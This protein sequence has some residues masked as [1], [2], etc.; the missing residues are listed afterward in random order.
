MS[1]YCRFPTCIA[2]RAAWTCLAAAFL[3]AGAAPAAQAAPQWTV[4]AEVSQGRAFVVRVYDNASSQEGSPRVSV[5]WRGKTVPLTVIPAK[6][7]GWEAEGLLAMPMDAK[8]S[9]PLTIQTGEEKHQLAVR[10]LPV[11]WHEDRITVAPKYVTPPPEVLAQIE[12]DR[13]HVTKALAASNPERMWT[14]P[15]YRPVKG[16]ISGPFGGRRVLNGKPRSPHKGT[17]MRGPQGTPVHAVA[18]GTVVLV[19]PQYYSGNVI[20]VDHGQ[21]VV[22]MYGHLSAFDVKPGDTVERGQVIGKVGATGRVTGPH[23]HLGLLI[24]GVAVDAMPLY[25][26]PLQVVGGPTPEDKV[27]RAAAPSAPAKAAAP[28]KQP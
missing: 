17:D 25:A 2:R 19:E 8:G 16:S 5:S 26:Q 28:R 14:L 3:L 11:P 10:A 9:L 21:G 7:S 13:E 6:T 20:Y 12:R 23:L 1:L 22:S 24:Q 27:V 4:P 15:F 18:A